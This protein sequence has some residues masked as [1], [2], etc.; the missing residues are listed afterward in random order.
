MARLRAAFVHEWFD[1]VEKSGL[2]ISEPVLHVHFPDGPEPVARRAARALLGSWERFLVDPSDATRRGRWSEAVLFDLLGWPRERFAGRHE[3]PED[4]WVRPDEVEETLRPSGVLRDAG[5]R[6]L[7]GW[8]SV[9]DG[10]RLDRVERRAGRWRATP[11]A[12][13]ERWM[14]G[15][16]VA[17]ALLANGRDFRLVHVP[18]GLPAA[19]LHFEASLWADEKAVLDGF[20]T[21]LSADRFFG[22]EKSRL[23][24][25][26]AESQER[27]TEL[28]DKLGLQVRSAVEKLIL[29]LDAAD[30]A[31]GGKILAG[32]SEEGVYRAAVY[33]VMRLVF[34]LF[35]EER[36][37]LPHGNVFY[38]EAYGLGRLLHRLEEERRQLVD[39]FQR[40]A[41][42]WPRLLA[43]FRLVFAGGRHPDLN[44]PAY[45]GDLFDPAGFD[46]MRVLEHPDL[47]IPNAAVYEILRALTFSE[48]KVGREKISQRYSY[49]I[50]DVEH[51]GYLYEGLLDH[52]AA[53]ASEEPMVKLRN[54]TEEAHPLAELEGRLGEALVDFLAA[55]K[56]FAGN[57]DRIEA[58]LEEPA[59]E[60]L[61]PLR[62]LSVAVAERCRPYAGVIQVEEIAEPGRFY[63]TTSASRRATG[64]HYT[65]IQ[66]TRAMVQETL[67]PLVH[68]G[69]HGKMEQPF[70]VRSP[71][72]L[73]DLKVC[74]PAMGSGAFLV[75]VIRYL[76]G[77]VAD[78]WWAERERHGEKVAL[79][80]P[81]A[82]SGDARADRI[83]V[84]GERDEAE[85]WARR[86]VAERCVYGV[87]KN[88]LA[89]EMAKLS[90]WLVTLSRDKPFSF[91]N[92]ALK[93]GDSLL[94][95][96][97]LD[98]LRTWTF[99]GKGTDVYITTERVEDA[100]ALRREIQRL[101]GETPEDVAEKAR[102]HREAESRVEGLRAL[103]D[104][105]FSTV[106]ADVNP[107][108]QAEM[109][110]RRLSAVVDRLDNSEAIAAMARQDLGEHRPFHWALEFPEVF[111][112]DE[113][114]FDAVV[115]NPPFMGG[116]KLTGVFGQPFREY[117][118]EHLANGVRGSA[119]LVAYFFLRA[120]VLLRET[121]NFGL[122]AVNTIAEGDTRQV[123]LE[124]LLKHR[125]VVYSASPNEPWPSMAAIVTSRVHVHKG[126]WEG[127]RLL[128]GEPVPRISPFLTS[129]EEWSPKRLVAN[130]NIAFIGSY[131][132]G[133]GFT[134]SSAE[135]LEM[136]D[137]DEKYRDVLFPY[138][139][140]KDLNSHPEQKA[141]RWVI[142]FW[143]WPEEKARSYEEAFDILEERVKPE[144]VK[145]KDNPS[146]R[147]RKQYWWLYGRDAKAL[148]HAIGRGEQFTKHPRE[149]TKKPPMNSVLVR[150]L[151]S[152]HNTF[153]PVSALQV[154]DQTLNVFALESPVMLACLSSE[155]HAAWFYY[156]G[157]TLGAGAYKRYIQSDTFETF[158]PPRSHWNEVAKLEYLPR[159]NLDWIT[160]TRQAM[161]SEQIGL[162]QLF[163]EINSRDSGLRIAENLRTLRAKIDCMLLRSYGWDD[164]DLGHDFH[165]VPYLP[166][167]D[168]V[169][170]TVSESARLEILDR[171]SQ[172]NRERYE[173]E[174]AQGLH[175][176]K[177]AKAK[178]P[179][180]PAPE[181]AEPARVLPFRRPPEP[182]VYPTTGQLPL[183]S[184]VAEPQ[185]VYDAE[186]G[187]EESV[188][189][190]AVSD[191]ELLGG[192]TPVE[193]IRGWLD[194]HPGWHARA[195]ALEGLGLTP[196]DWNPAIKELVTF[197]EVEKK[198]EKRGAR[199][200]LVPDYSAHRLL[201][202]FEANPGWHGRG[203]VLE[204]LAL[205][206]AEWSEAIRELVELGEVEK[207]G[208]K[209][210]TR[211]KGKSAD[212]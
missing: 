145:L 190:L 73:L 39:T 86:L 52:R 41:D 8:W 191:E 40:E 140:G 49:R 107:Q 201:D 182:D 193:R 157:A 36:N 20:V 209:R 56:V 114:G 3:V 105:L 113:G 155:I 186:H 57:R 50:L 72:E 132:L 184:Q 83:P 165:E 35:A 102:L 123:G 62:R 198:G 185:A 117:L 179:P 130:S 23:E 143:D 173:E 101:P 26:V 128:L 34:L 80:L 81:Y 59:E 151:N 108:R 111:D 9:P 118:V 76:G 139:N 68:V 65:P 48:A 162:T 138:I 71:R 136:I 78:A 131:I 95:L 211:Y 38:D 27:Q 121:G 160:K 61:E 197:G 47:R 110:A 77:K 82:E 177:K 195:E 90:L 188:E 124:R 7:L 192:G 88:P 100:V 1:L 5:G 14:R 171:L 112:R 10:Q 104:L 51:I 115:G 149:W 158:P 156:L 18:P 13:L 60:D 22:P 116:Q 142:N 176:K 106:I 98:Q 79:H 196:Q 97:S 181:L 109:Q 122:L 45:G 189:E 94:G 4:L 212:G 148:Y 200:R 127:G 15:A 159:L 137:R 54:G 6:A 85:L 75:Q 63:L 119:D 208:E 70:R 183:L 202:W 53:R 96:T 180:K 37:L 153:F 89:V 66:Y 28:T 32:L 161:R 135:A 168:R 12:K 126:P 103:G 163:N 167:N 99:D 203:D 166:E 204:A 33:A 129:G 125:G 175:G 170:F 172:L 24:R 174:V 84:P 146:A 120:F 147:R 30:H 2:V 134:L 29:A 25:L 92:H 44:L 67:D 205:S 93:S 169:R 144:R 74:D 16:R 152:K 43:L 42:A 199:Y 55:E 187:A 133:M 141:S 69:E 194:A 91:V 207:K 11:Q 21:L 17:L 178:R 210:G 19:W 87:D 164:L 46:A 150:A 206:V 64:T 58:R 31:R 154:L